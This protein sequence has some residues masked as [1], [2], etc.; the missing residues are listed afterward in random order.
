MTNTSK[1]S[2]KVSDGTEMAAFVAKPSGPGPH[3]GILVFQE[4]FG[5]N[6]HIQNVAK[7]FAEEGYVALAPELFHRTAQPGLTL[8]YGNFA[9][10]L[11]HMQAMT[12][13]TLEADVRAGFDWLQ[14]LAEVQK[15]RIGCV[16]YCMGG[17]TSF[18]ANSVVPL[19]AAISYYGGGI[20]P[21]ERGPGL[22]ARAGKQ[23]API[24]LF[25]GG[26][27][28]HIG[29]TQSRAVSDALRA[30]GKSFVDVEFSFADHAF[31]NDER[32]SYNAQAS[33]QAWLLTLAFLRE[34]LA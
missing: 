28:Q 23:H 5:V 24:L 19:K 6:S 30:A 8:E 9:P 14:G 31:N 34:N 11:P 22:L 3:P 2:L 15:G 20:A 29:P 18:L 4:A 10:I 7:R 26:L 12:E 17:R 21:S 25:W 16:G 32:P 27:D 13:S 1:V 33:K